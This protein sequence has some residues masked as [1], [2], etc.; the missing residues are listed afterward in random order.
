MSDISGFGLSINLVASITFP[1]GIDITQF[2]DDAD[3]FDNPSIQLR[4][5]AMGLNGDL[6][7]WSKAV[8][9]P[10]TLNVIPNGEDDDNLQV[11]AVANRVGKGRRAV[12][13][14]ITIT[15]NYPDGAQITLSN[16]A[17]TDA[18]L[19]NGVASAGR[20]KTKAYPF[21]FENIDN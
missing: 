10:F 21:V 13:D 20:M 11:L 15:V 8:P 18:M 6:V 19:G 3:P 4:D 1:G 9:I 12:Q 14:I 16:G 7:V 5:K 17:I 2:A